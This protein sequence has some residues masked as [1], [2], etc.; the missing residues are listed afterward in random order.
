MINKVGVMCFSEMYGKPMVFYT[1]QEY[2]CGLVVVHLKVCMYK[3]MHV[4]M[5]V[6]S[7][8]YVCVDLDA[9]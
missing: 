7:Y 5:C 4:C 6:N 9:Y 2:R 1:F 8:M 3:V